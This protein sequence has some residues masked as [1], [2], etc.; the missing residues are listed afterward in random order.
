ML[1][2]DDAACHHLSTLEGKRVRTN[3]FLEEVSRVTTAIDDV[4]KHHLSVFNKIEPKL[5]QLLKSV[6]PSI[7]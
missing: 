7:N 2:E 4:L 1:S 3:R 6:F 5:K